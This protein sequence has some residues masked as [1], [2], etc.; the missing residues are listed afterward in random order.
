[1]LSIKIKEYNND[2]AVHPREVCFSRSLDT[3]T[4]EYDKFKE[5]QGEMVS[6]N[7]I[8]V[9]ADKAQ[10]NNSLMSDLLM[11]RTT[12]IRVGDHSYTVNIVS[13]CIV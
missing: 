13:Q 7:N 6:I 2:E 12:T 8:V 4:D 11:K 9:T 1:M 5:S 3:I 10:L